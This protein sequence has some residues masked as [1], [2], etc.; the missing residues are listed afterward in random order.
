MTPNF[1]ALILD[2]DST[3]SGIEGIDWLARRRDAHVA[4]AIEALTSRAMAGEIPLEAIYEERL[5]IIRPTRAEIDALADAYIA[6]RSPGVDEAVAALRAAGVRM[7]VV[8]GGIRQAILPLTRRLG[9]ADDVVDAVHLRFGDGDACVG[10]E[11]SPLTT[12]VG[13]PRSP[14]V[15]DLP[16][17]VLAVGDGM[18]DLVLRAPPGRLFAAYTGF[19]ARGP[20][21]EGADYVVESF[22]A[23]R[24]LVLDPDSS[25]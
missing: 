13:K 5:T 15:Q 14:V 12:Q 9:F 4:E 20:V 2:V 7:A 17:P 23:L 8:S 18:T 16:A 24:A 1:Q 3:L 11:P 10:I 19:V 22:A 21:V 25:S 6:A